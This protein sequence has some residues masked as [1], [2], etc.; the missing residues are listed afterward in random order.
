MDDKLLNDILGI[1][2]FFGAIGLYM[3]FMGYGIW[4][5]FGRLKKCPECKTRL[6][7]MNDCW[8]HEKS[9]CKNSEL[10]LYTDEDFQ[11]WNKGRFINS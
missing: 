3:T 8:A 4:F 2:I 6:R 7:K 9:G 5:F 1:V 11:N 10:E